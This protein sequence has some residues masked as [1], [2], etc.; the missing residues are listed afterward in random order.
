MQGVGLSL[1]SGVVSCHL[2][3]VLSDE[4][5]QGENLFPSCPLLVSLPESM[6]SSVIL[7]F[8]G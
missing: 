5:R 6:S 2:R 4:T 3:I 8:P 1:I 7:L